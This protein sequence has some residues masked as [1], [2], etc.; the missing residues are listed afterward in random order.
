MIQ[1]DYCAKGKSCMC[2]VDL[3]K[4]CDKS[5]KESFEEDNIPQVLGK[6]VCM[7][8]QS[9]DSEWIAICLRSW[10]LRWDAPR[11]CV[12]TFV[13]QLWWVL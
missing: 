13:L 10:S 7:R 4:A 6:S 5:I 8:E 2:F 12:V 1:E 9:Q 3:E 11:I